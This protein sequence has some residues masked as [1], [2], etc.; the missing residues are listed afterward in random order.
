M[1][2]THLKYHGCP[3]QSY[4]DGPAFF[5]FR[6]ELQ[7]LENAI[8]LRTKNQEAIQYGLFRGGT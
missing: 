5:Q 8:Q 7:V 4:R 3:T 2:P 1:W 6:S